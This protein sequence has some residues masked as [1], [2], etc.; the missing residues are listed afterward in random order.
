MRRFLGKIVTLMLFLTIMEVSL[1]LAQEKDEVL[2]KIGNEVITRSDFEIKLR[3]LPQ[4]V[5]DRVKS[6][7]MKKAL[8]DAM[9][10]ARLFVMEG[11][12][13]G[14]NERPEIKSY[15]RIVRD[16]YITQE[17]VRA[18]LEK[19][20]EVSDEEAQ[21]YYDTDPEIRERELLK[22][23]QIAVEKESEAKDILERLK[24]GEPFRKL[25]YEKSVD[26]IT[27]RGGEMEWFE[28]GKGEKEV[29]EAV[30]KLEIQG[31][32][33]VVKAKGRYYI[34][35]L[36]D[37]KTVPKPSYLK[38]KDEII[39]R[40]KYKKIAELAEKEVEEMKKKVTIETFYDKLPSE[41]R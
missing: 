16:D 12:K 22:V 10:K 32:S 11:E 14:L 13:K 15:L 5:Q 4:K 24:K 26:P 37:K 29:E 1:V 6:P 31:L 23:S 38:K 19:D 28:K 3:S 35:K 25:A 2:A 34:F 17:Y 41:E 39:S 9:V 30:A 36:D 33:E 20:A 40:L 18:Y 21:R 8:L 27:T 7:E